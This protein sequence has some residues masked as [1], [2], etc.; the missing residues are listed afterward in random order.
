MLNQDCATYSAG[1]VEDL[2]HALLSVHLDHLAVAVL[3]RRVVLLHE[4]AL[5]E[6]HRLQN[7]SNSVTTHVHNAKTAP[8]GPVHM[9]R[10]TPAQIRSH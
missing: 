2:E 7:T 4:D 9:D 1:G 5:H 8:L 10:C 6:L 3:D